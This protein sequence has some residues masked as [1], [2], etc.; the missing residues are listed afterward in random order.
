MIKELLK[1]I[2]N[3]FNKFDHF[4]TRN[5]NEQFKKSDLYTFA[6]TLD[7]FSSLNLK[8]IFIKILKENIQSLDSKG[9]SARSHHVEGSIDV[10]MNE[11]GVVLEGRAGLNAEERAGLNAEERAGLNAEERAGL[12]IDETDLIHENILYL[13]SVVRF[14][15]LS[16][17]DFHPFFIN[18]LNNIVSMLRKSCLS[19][20]THHLIMRYYS[21][22]AIA[23]LSGMSDQEKEL[24][25][26][27]VFPTEQD[28]VL[29]KAEYVLIYV[30]FL[31]L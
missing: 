12:A 29:A 8:N 30:S 9:S 31:K 26:Q 2:K 10:V 5:E 18:D 23:L 28:L 21:V 17:S 22:L 25:L 14:C 15:L 20:S 24:L 1:T 13:K 4:K 11:T 6:I 16:I 7:L 19:N 27:R 3:K